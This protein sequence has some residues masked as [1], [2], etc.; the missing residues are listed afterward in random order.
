MALGP[1]GMNWQAAH[2]WLATLGAVA[3]ASFVWI[4]RQWN[5]INRVEQGL[6]EVCG[7][8]DTLQQDV[9]ELRKIIIR[10]NH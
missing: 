9:R 2:S 10:N 7:K 5:K 3:V 1:D 8:L 4:A 6:G